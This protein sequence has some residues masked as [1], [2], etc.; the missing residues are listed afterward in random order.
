EQAYHHLQQTQQQLVQSEKMASLGQLTAG[1]AHEINNPINFVSANVNPLKRNFT[2]LVDLIKNKKEFSDD[3][4]N[5]TISESYQL[6]TGIEE[7]S[8]RTA[9]I[10]KGL[11]NFSRLDE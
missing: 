7:G 11:R 2:E 6:L 10:V 9:E 3:E 5:Y 4:L 8:R 1:V